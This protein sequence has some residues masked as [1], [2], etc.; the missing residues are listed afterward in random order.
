MLSLRTLFRALAANLSE[1]QNGEFVSAKDMYTVAMS[2]G[3]EAEGAD[4]GRRAPTLTAMINAFENLSPEEQQIA[5]NGLTERLI[6]FGPKRAKRA[7]S[8]LQK[9]GYT[10]ANE[11][12][13]P[14]DPQP[15]E[16]GTAPDSAVAAAPKENKSSF[17]S[18]FNNYTSVRLLGSG[19]SG[20]VYE[21]VDKD[22]NHFALKVID[23]RKATSQKLK[24]FQNEIA[25]CQKHTHENLI[26]VVDHGPAPSGGPFYVMPLYPGTLEKV[27]SGPL[28]AAEVLPV[29]SQILNGVEAAHKK[30]AA[31]RDLKPQNI[32]CDLNNHKVV[33][34]DFGIASFREEDLYT[35]AETHPAERLANFQYA[36]PEQRAR[37][38]EVSWQADVY[39]LGL[40]LNQM[41][42]GEILQGTGFKTIGSVAPEYAFLDAIVEHMVRQDPTERPSIEDVKKQLLAR[43]QDFVILQKIDGLTHQVV[44]EQSIDDPLVVN[45]IELEKV[46]YRDGTLFLTLSK[47]PNGK[48]VQEFQ[49]QGSFRSFLGRGPGTVRFDPSGTASIPVRANEAQPQVDFFKS[50]IHNANQAY[51]ARIGR[52]AEA[53]RRRRQA[54]IDNQLRLERERQQVLEN[55]KW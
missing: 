11:S 43:Q 40:I 10:W 26:S 23:P 8:I 50:W 24:R 12:A 4:V 20:D 45:P 35:A 1:E 55:L 33:V 49:Q 52:E 9:H 32:L 48:W 14:T 31:H 39:A 38:R 16:R 30:G 21:V 17:R 41:F 19:G 7:K 34:A 6:K 25:F 37:G 18:A 47:A 2:L 28:P 44:P 5:V 22:G 53:E 13:V 54:E 3:L 51:A 42:T 27:L 46:D 36:A 29:F 15:P